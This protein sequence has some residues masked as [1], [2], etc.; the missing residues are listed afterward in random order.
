MNPSAPVPGQPKGNARHCW[1]SCY[2]H[3]WR[4][5]HI[6]KNYEYAHSLFTECVVH[7]PAN[8]S[9]VETLLQNL[10]L[11]HPS[12]NR[13]SLFGARTGRTLKQA[14]GNGDFVKAFQIGIELLKAD[15]WD[16]ATLR[17]MADACS[18]LHFN[19]VE[20]VYLKQA[21]DG[22]PKDIEVNRH[23]ARSLAR[24]GQFDQAIACWHRIEV[25]H[26]GDK[27]PS[28]MISLLQEEKQKY[29]HRRP[30]IAE[31]PRAATKP[32]VTTRESIEEATAP[33][34][35]PRQILEQAISA[36]PQKVSNYLDFAELLADAEKFSDAEKVLLR[37]IAACGEHDGLIG[38]LTQIQMLRADHER[39]IDEAR[40]TAELKAQRRPW[41]FSWLEL[42]LAVALIVLIVQLSSPLARF[43]WHA[44]DIRHWSRLTWFVI[45]VTVV[46]LLCALRYGPGP[47]FFQSWQKRKKLRVEKAS[48]RRIP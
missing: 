21:L 44:F 36:E 14:V 7:D 3:G 28:K 8:L 45:N 2:Q 1:E 10:R 42:A 26:P 22:N 41:R 31:K 23:C 13:H 35:S 43:V 20:L 11:I 46:A 12:P 37:G 47:N 16:T 17:A 9:Y 34:L 40:R 27:E 33:T 30:P 5:M 32:Q 6:E 19:D 39:A 48:A 25:Q 24:M 29:P 4:L 15:P 18:Q 38:K